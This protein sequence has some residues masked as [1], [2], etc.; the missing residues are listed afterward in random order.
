MAT[1]GFFS[2]QLDI[3]RTKYINKKNFIEKNADR[4]FDNDVHEDFVKHSLNVKEN[5]D[6]VISGLGWFKFSEAS[7]VN[8]Y[9]YKGVGI[10]KRTSLV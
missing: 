6:I 9:T 3:H 8:I 2:E 1:V 10:V 5:E 7:I 4:Y